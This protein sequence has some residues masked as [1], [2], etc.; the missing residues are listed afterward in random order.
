VASSP[1][2]DDLERRIAGDPGSVSFALLAEEYRRMGRLAEAIRVARSGLVARPAYASARVTL[3]R[4]LIEN[5]NLAD[6]RAELEA[7][8]ALA[9]ENLLA[10][11]ALA[12][13]CQRESAAAP[14]DVPTAR[15]AEAVP[16]ERPAERPTVA[17]EVAPEESSEVVSDIGSEVAPEVGSEP[18]AMSEGMHET[19]DSGSLD[20]A[21]EQAPAVPE[22]RPVLWH[23]APPLSHEAI[24]LA[25]L[26]EWL[27]LLLEDRTSRHEREV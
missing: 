18:V 8:L 16:A 13:I 1:R 24:A 27:R 11:R 14:P 6:A 5:G 15:S 17:R 9:P 2:I 21:Q 20:P 12:E 7:G 10:R 26:D 23:E 4:A 25:R 22:P 3:G 19:A